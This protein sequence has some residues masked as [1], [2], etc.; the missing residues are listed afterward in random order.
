M[1][2]DGSDIVKVINPTPKSHMVQGIK[3]A[4]KGMRMIGRIAISSVT[5][6]ASYVTGAQDGTDHEIENRRK[7]F[8]YSHVLDPVHKK[9]LQKFEE[10]E[11]LIKKFL[12]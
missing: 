6:V 4:A 9:A 11:N 12:S 2:L 5:S 8:D 10:D 3:G 7:S 1:F